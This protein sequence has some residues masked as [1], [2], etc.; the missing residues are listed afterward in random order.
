[1]HALRNCDRKTISDDLVR[2]LRHP[3]P[4]V[5]HHAAQALVRLDVAEAV[6]SLIA[7]LDEPDPAAPFTV[8]AMGAKV[9]VVREMVRLNHHRNCQ[10]CHAPGESDVRGSGAL[11][12][13]RVPSPADPLPPSLSR[14]YYSVS[15]REIDQVIR[16][17]VTYLRQDFSLLQ[18]VPDAKPWPEMQRF[19]YLVRLRAVGDDECAKLPQAKTDALSAQHEYALAALRELTWQDHGPTADAWR[20]AELRNTRKTALSQ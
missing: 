5:A 9:T 16:A 6:P 19:D 13:A 11:L 18:K 17:D 12:M 14:V 3:A 1:L 7:F 8:R 4:A 10:L 15:P 20:R 2:G